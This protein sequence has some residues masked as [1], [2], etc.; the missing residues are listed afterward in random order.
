VIPV[1]SSRVG[2]PHDRRRQIVDGFAYLEVAP[3]LEAALL[4]D[5]YRTH[6]A[7]K[8]VPG[9]YGPDKAGKRPV[10]SQ[11][12]SSLGSIIWNFSVESAV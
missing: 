12:R 1:L 10:I 2:R 6:A 7:L 8:E 3:E 11:K 5:V 9:D 4:L